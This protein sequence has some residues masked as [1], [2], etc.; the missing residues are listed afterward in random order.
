MINVK[1]IKNPLKIKKYF[2]EIYKSAYKNTNPEY[3]ETTNE[4][5]ERYFK[6]LHNHAPDGFIFLYFNKKPVGFAVV[7]FDWYDDKLNDVVAEIHEICIKKEYQ[8]KGLGKIL[9]DKITE[10]AKNKKLKFLCGYVGKE[11]YQSLNFFKKY[12]FEEN[13][14]RW[15]IWRRIRKRLF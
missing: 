10:F 14:I 7:D 4:E 5:I 15:G 1:I 2:I 9:L 8:N 11:N 6:W 12:G 3:Y 13:E